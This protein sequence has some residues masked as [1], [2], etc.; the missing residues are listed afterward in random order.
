MTAVFA[1]AALC[2]VIIVHEFGHYAAAVATGMKVDRFSVFGIGTPI[3]RLGTWRGTEFV[4]SAI[5]FGAYVQ[6]RGME[7]NDD[8]A[9]APSDGSPNYRDKPLLS[10]MLVIVGGPVANYLAAMAVLLGVYASVGVEGPPTAL[11]VAGT[12]ADGAAQAA[13]LEPGDQILSVGETTID[14]A[15]RGLDVAQAAQ[16]ARGGKLEIVVARG[17]GR[18]HLVAELPS[19]GETPLGVDMRVVAPRVAVGFGDALGRAVADPIRLSGAQLV[20]LWMLV[21]GQIQATV[22][23]PVGIV[24]E[25]AK[26]AEAG[27]LPFVLLVATIS[28]LLGLFNLLPLPALDGGRFAFLVYEGVARR[29]ANPRIEES[30]HGYGMMVLLALILLFTVGDVRRLF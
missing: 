5:P 16:A 4:I 18:V 9:S 7:A 1:I 24:H 17:D 6:I 20:G 8:E 30:I 12:R 21:T 22:Q 11:E 27:L 26:A 14:P 2:V 25:I 15:Q 10:R 28:T 19:E 13:G 3:V 23:G 29:R